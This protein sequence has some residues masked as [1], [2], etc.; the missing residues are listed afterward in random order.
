MCR[1]QHFTGISAI[2]RPLSVRA[3]LERLAGTWCGGRLAEQLHV[4]VAREY[5]VQHLRYGRKIKAIVGL[6]SVPDP[7]E[8]PTTALVMTFLDTRHKNP[9]LGCGREFK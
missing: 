2:S 7:L 6:I 4:L 9:P 3:I 1:F 8:H 5:N